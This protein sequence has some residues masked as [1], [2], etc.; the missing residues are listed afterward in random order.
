MARLSSALAWAIFL[1]A[2]ACRDCSWAPMF[3]PTSIS[4]ISME[5]ISKAVPESSPLLRTRFEMSSGFSSTS[6]WDCAEPTVVTM[7]SPILARI[8]ASP[9]P[10]TRRS[11]SA[12][13]VTLAF[14]RSSIPSF[15]TADTLVVSMTLGFTLI[16]TASRTSRPARSIA[17]AFSK[18]SSM[19]ALSDAINALTTLST[20]P[21]A[22]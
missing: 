6:L 5:R 16:F 18:G 2:S 3:L 8:V 22:R 1:S 7:P 17:A 13:T 15:A 12:L 21:P 14:T 11:R 9:A 19:P 4:A 20:L 10:P